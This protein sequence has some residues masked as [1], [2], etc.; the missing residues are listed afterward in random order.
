MNTDLS[1]NMARKQRSEAVLAAEG[2]PV[3]SYLPVIESEA[4]VMRHS[5]EE[6]AYHALSLLI[7]AA[8]GEGLDAETVNRVVADYGLASHLSPK[9][10]A[11]IADPASPEQ[12]RVP[13]VWR[14]ESAW[15]LLWALGYIEEL[16]KPTGIC[17]VPRAVRCMQ[18]RSPAQFIAQSNLRPISEIL[19]Q[20]DRI[21]RYDWAVVNAR[22]GG[23]PAPAQLEPG[24]VWER[25]YALNWLIGYQ[26][27]NWDDITTDT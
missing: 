27:Q 20:A 9:E 16:T 7:V 4:D 3:N 22:M 8:K 23:A 10:G 24:V 1:E 18:E 21:Y 13:F 12:D 5:Q 26:N 6:V 14:Y 2:V 17:D 15:T 19:E 11:F 25:H